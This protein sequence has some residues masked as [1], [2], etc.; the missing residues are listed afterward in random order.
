MKFDDC[1]NKNPLPFDFYLPNYNIC[2][3][4]DGRQHYLPIFYFGGEKMLN[5]TKNN[6]NIKNEY[7]LNNN[8]KLVRIPYYEINDIENI[9]SSIFMIF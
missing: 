6:D 3:E 9:I 7:C 1:R 5:Y 2:I 8:I 4:F